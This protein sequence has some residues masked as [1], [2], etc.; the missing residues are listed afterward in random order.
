[1]DYQ[2]TVSIESI[3]NESEAAAQPIHILPCEIDHTG[4]AKV[5]EYFQGDDEQWATFRGHPIHS[6]E[7]TLPNGYAMNVLKG[8]ISPYSLPFFS[9]R[10]VDEFENVEQQIHFVESKQNELISWERD[11]VSKFSSDLQKTLDFLTVAEAF[12]ADDE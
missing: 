2:P 5:S 8:K 12:A 4:E 10:D 9:E 7:I 6:T 1:M 3:K 11:E